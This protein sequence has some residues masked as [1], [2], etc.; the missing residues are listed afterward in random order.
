MALINGAL[1]IGRSAILTSQ[2]A[3]AV[4]GNNIAN[5]ATASYTRQKVH[6]TPTQYAEVLPGK[7]T[8]TG[9]TIYDIRRQIDDALT[10]RIRNAVSD[11]A[12]NLVQ[13]QAMARVEAAFNELTD[14]DLSSRMNAFFGAWSSLQSQPQDNASR[15][16]V[17]QS[18]SSLTSFVT[19]LRGELRNVQTDLDTQVRYQ[20]SE[21]DALARQIAGLNEDI[22]VAESG[23]AGSASALRD[24]RDESLKQLSELIN[25]T[26]HEV[27]GGSVN[28]YIGSEPLIQYSDCRGLDYVEEEDINGNKLSKVVFSN[29]NDTARMDGGKIYG[30]ITARDDQVGNI[31]SDLDDWATGMIFEVNKL[32]SLGCGLDGLSSV[33]ATYDVA[34]ADAS[35]A[36]MDDTELPWQVSNGVFTVNVYDSNGLVV[37]SEQIKV[38]IG[39]NGSDTTLNTLAAS[40]DAVDGIDAYVDGAN[41]LHIDASNSG[42]TFTFA[43]PGDA[44][45][46]N[47]LAALGINTFF[48]GTTAADIQVNS[49]LTDSPRNIA[50]ASAAGKAGNGDVAGAI[51]ALATTGV[52]S[53]DGNSIADHFSSMVSEIATNTKRTQDNYS[54]ADVV[55]Q[56]LELERQSISGVSVDEEAMNIIIFQRAFQG[57]AR[58][59]S[60][61]NDM[62]DEIINLL[63]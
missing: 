5:A 29:N 11:S 8:G 60:V 20:V 16:V 3:L 9:V 30:L 43:S 61:I 1:Q 34:D 55:V 14:E 56:T 47:V 18:A 35:L 49:D 13:Q 54:A 7:Y 6:L 21:A 4:T 48:E 25:V 37:N 41:I 19:E 26:S 17:L 59:V 2:A 42:G 52:S 10:G 40:L 23:C 44:S 33:T 24:Q 39:V 46:T 12:S 31:I 50:A 45:A 27:E 58:Y 32:H 38:D 62:L 15:S 53:F 28:V 22:V 57:A 36:E 63:D 51:A